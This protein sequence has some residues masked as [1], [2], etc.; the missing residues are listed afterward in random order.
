MDFSIVVLLWLNFLLFLRLRD[1]H[2][3]TLYIIVSELILRVEG[4]P[5]NQHTTI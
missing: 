3:S 4:L 2:N 5:S 1:K